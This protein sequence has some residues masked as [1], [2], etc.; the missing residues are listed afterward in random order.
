MAKSVGWQKVIRDRLFFSARSTAGRWML[1]TGKSSNGYLEDPHPVEINHRHG[2]STSV[3]PNLIET[4]NGFLMLFAGRKGR[5]ETLRLFMARSSSLDGPWELSDQIYASNK[6][7]EGRNIDLGPGNY[8]EGAF[9]Y[10]FYSSA[11][12]RLRTLIGSMLKAPRIPN[13][14][15]LMRFE[16]RRIGVLSLDPANL[17]FVASSEEPLPLKSE[18]GTVSESVF[19]PGYLR[20]ADRHI[21]FVTASNYS[22]GFPFEQIIGSVD[23]ELPPHKW[24]ELKSISPLL[25]SKDLSGTLSSRTAFDTPDPIPVNGNTAILYFS[26]MSRDDDEWCVLKCKLMIDS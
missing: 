3:T 19:C 22:M 9:A 14:A 26:A 11:Y 17:K 2:F 21:L 6:R 25:T 13:S 23:S 10:F 12:P 8:R 5:F 15:N 20:M 16:K 4:E 7:W 18:H 1:G 24:R